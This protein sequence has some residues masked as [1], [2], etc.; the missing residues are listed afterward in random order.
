M[1]HVDMPMDG[2]IYRILPLR[3]YALY[4]KNGRFRIRSQLFQ[5]SNLL[6]PSENPKYEI[7]FYNSWPTYTL[8]NCFEEPTVAYFKRRN[9]VVYLILNWEPIPLTYIFPPLA[10]SMKQ[11]INSI[12]AQ[13]RNIIEYSRFTFT[14]LFVP[15]RATSSHHLQ[16]S[17]NSNCHSD[18][19]DMAAP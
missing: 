9:Q 2:R 11:K 8:R 6:Q 10:I 14:L 17:E 4:A 16:Q 18:L 3:V 12:I 15:Q 13:P 5:H 7:D 19:V 1:K